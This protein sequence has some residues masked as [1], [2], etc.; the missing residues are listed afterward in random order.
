MPREDDFDDDDR[1]RDDEFDDRPRRR[2]RFDDDDDLP[3]RRPA[4]KSNLALILGILAGVLFLFCAGG[5]VALWYAGTKIGGAADRMSSSNNLKQIDLACQNYHDTYNGFPT[6]SY[7]RD[8]KPL[9]SWRVH[10]LPFIEEDQLYRQFHL[11]EP[12]D[13]QNNIRLLNQM[14]RVYAT[15]PEARGKVAK[16]TMTYYRGFTS[17]GAMFARRD[18]GRPMFG[19]PGAGFG[20]PGLPGPPVGIR[21]T[22]VT[23]GTANTI[24]VVEAGQATEWSKPGDLD[25]SPGK[26]F[27]P[28]GGVRP[29][30]D[31]L[32]AVTVNG[33]VH[34]FRKDKPEAEWRALITYSGGEIVSLD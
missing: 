25:A 20:P 7:D 19:P 14:P 26:P 16:G 34:T 28:L 31:Q 11:D 33:M 23:D 10:I 27:P 1:R 18:N 17:P 6:D 3:P 22:D 8:G 2:R 30:A 21:V 32:L 5:V 29:K 24:L 13:S 4:K 15:P 12:W 9:L